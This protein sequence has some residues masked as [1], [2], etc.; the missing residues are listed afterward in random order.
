MTRKQAQELADKVNAIED[1][2][3]RAEVEEIT[4][5]HLPGYPAA[6]VVKHIESGNQIGRAE[7]LT[8][9]Q[10]IARCIIERFRSD[11]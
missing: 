7:Y 10:Y 11:S 3:Y 2:G 9:G 8:E 4:N 1:S 5:A 6:F